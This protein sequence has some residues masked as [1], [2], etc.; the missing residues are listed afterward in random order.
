M[1]RS[2]SERCFLKSSGILGAVPTLPSSSGEAPK[3]EAGST[4][5]SPHLL[6]MI[7]FV[8]CSGNFDLGLGPGPG[9]GLG[10]GMGMCSMNSPGSSSEAARE[11]DTEK[12]K[13]E[14]AEDKDKDSSEWSYHQEAEH[15]FELAR[16]AL[17]AGK[18]WVMGMGLLVRLDWVADSIPTPIHKPRCIFTSSVVPWIPR[19]SKTRRKLAENDFERGANDVVNLEKEEAANKHHIDKLEQQCE[20]IAEEQHLFGQE[21]TQYYLEAMGVKDMRANAEELEKS[22]QAKKV[23]PKLMNMLEVLEKRE[24]GLK[25]MLTTILKDKEKI[26]DTIEEL[27]QCDALMK[28][29]KKAEGDF[30]GIFVELLPGNFAK[31][32]PPEYQDL[33]DDLEVKVQLGSVWKQSLTELS[34]GQRSLIALSLIMA[35]LQ[36]QPAPMHILEKIDA[37]LDLSRTQH[38]GQLFRTPFKGSQL[39]VVSLKEGLF[40]NVDVLFRTRFR[41]G[42]SIVERTANRSSSTL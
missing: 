14:N 10:P 15:R 35:L 22:Q 21:G 28:T 12:D 26:E 5:P 30:G 7:F 29:W 32:Q 34:G 20:Q 4:I 24:V 19:P 38:T 2:I 39:I 42:T 11:K 23:N 18:F 1:D 6:A 36:F 27:D 17:V 16:K 13:D 37:A 8:F 9:L 25:K 3:A 33:T 40:T 41:D 31:L